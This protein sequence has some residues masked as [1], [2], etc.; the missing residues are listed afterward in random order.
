MNENEVKEILKD[1]IKELNPKIHDKWFLGMIG[2]MGFRF[3]NNGNMVELS[4]RIGRINKICVFKVKDVIEAYDE[5]N[6]KDFIYDYVLSTSETYY[7]DSLD[8]IGRELGYV[9]NGNAN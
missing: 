5:G 3:T 8:A 2:I 7:Q 9:T 4:I 1:A 6:V